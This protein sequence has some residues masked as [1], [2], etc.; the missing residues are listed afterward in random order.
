MDAHG[1]ILILLEE[2][3]LFAV[4]AVKGDPGM[5]YL[6]A[7]AKTLDVFQNGMSP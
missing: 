5:S 1:E 4:T 2:T 3:N 6:C 7:Q